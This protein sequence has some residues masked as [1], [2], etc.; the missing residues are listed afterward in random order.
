MKKN[1]DLEMQGK[2]T[3]SDS[4]NLKHWLAFQR[5]IQV[6]KMCTGGDIKMTSVHNAL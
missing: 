1:I 6:Y 2:T 5:V 4:S 3:K